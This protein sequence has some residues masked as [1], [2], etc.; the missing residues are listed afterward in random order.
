VQHHAPAALQHA[1]RFVAERRQDAN[2]V[3]LLAGC[4]ECRHEMRHAGMVDPAADTQV[5]SI[6]AMQKF[7][8]R[9]FRYFGWGS[10][11]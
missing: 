3:A 1:M 4:V 7:A 11:G 8:N 5:R 9:D 6:Q 2:L 10:I